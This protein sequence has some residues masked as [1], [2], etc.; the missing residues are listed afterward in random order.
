MVNIKGVNFT[1]L[2]FNKHDYKIKPLD[3]PTHALMS[4]QT[5]LSMQSSQSTR[6]TQT[7]SESIELDAVV[8]LEDIPELMK[9][10]PVSM[11]KMQGKE[12]LEYLKKMIE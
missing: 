2:H 11:K 3:V 4:L 10:Y 8:K 9:E 12:R 5:I 1:L 6:S 7:Q